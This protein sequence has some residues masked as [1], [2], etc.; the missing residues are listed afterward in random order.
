MDYCNSLLVGLPKNE[1]FKL[2]H[3]MNSAARMITGTKKF[4]HIIPVLTDLHW[5]PVIIINNSNHVIS[6]ILI[7]VSL[8]FQTT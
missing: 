8:A 1:L 4:S 6:E 5:L 3:I 2:Q 7:L